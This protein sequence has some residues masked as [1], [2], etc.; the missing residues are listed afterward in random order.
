M[1]DMNLSL[2][3]DDGSGVTLVRLVISRPYGVLLRKFH[4]C[5]IGIVPVS[6]NWVSPA[7]NGVE[8]HDNGFCEVTHKVKWIIM[9]IKRMVMVLSLGNPDMG[10]FFANL[11]TVGEIEA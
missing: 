7:L 9:M 4:S 2:G 8:F 11:A 6:V 10:I 5:S 3:R 1:A